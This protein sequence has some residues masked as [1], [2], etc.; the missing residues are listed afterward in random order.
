MRLSEAEYRYLRSGA[1]S[2]GYRT[3]KLE[4][5]IEERVELLPVRFEMLFE[6]IEQ[7]HEGRF[8]SDNDSGDRRGNKPEPDDTPK[9]AEG[10]HYRPL[11]TESGLRALIT[12]LGFEDKTRQEVID[13]LTYSGDSR[14]SASAD[15]GAKLGLMVHRIMGQS[16]LE[17]EH[18][19]RDEVVADLIW[20][21]LKGLCFDWREASSVTAELIED[22][23]SDMIDR[24]R[25]RIE[26]AADS[27][28]NWESFM[29]NTKDIKNPCQSPWSDVRDE[30]ADHV[31]ELLAKQDITTGRQLE[32][33]NQNIRRVNIQDNEVK[34]CYTVVDHLIDHLI[35]SDARMNTK[36]HLRDFKDEY[37]PLKEFEIDAV[38]TEDLVN[39]VLE[40]KQLR[41]QIQLINLVEKD[42]ECL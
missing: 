8:K 37:G 33:K 28:R 11:D 17:P 31:N 1:A 24:T 30:M 14:E 15:F 35:D 25:K 29:Q 3:D 5:K 23:S 41:E 38:V 20:G 36:G 22:V 10:D 2:D 4:K 9:P 26:P 12:L 6:D 21:F 13:G 18:V 39:H 19:D 27:R 42:V 7:L 32:L 34:L 40:D 16:G